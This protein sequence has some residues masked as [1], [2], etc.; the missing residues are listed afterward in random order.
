MLAI[1]YAMV[2]YP[3]IGAIVGHGYPSAPLFGVAPCPT[4]IF[5]FGFFLWS[6][7]GLPRYLLVVPF[8]WALLGTNAALPPFGI[9]EDFGLLVSAVVGSAL[10]LWRRGPRVEAQVG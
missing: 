8:L 9:L 4:T 10:L 2:A 5:T 1:F 6:K 7:P 3:M